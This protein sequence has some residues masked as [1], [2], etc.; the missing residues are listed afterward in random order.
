MN[1]YTFAVN[2]V[3]DKGVHEKQAGETVQI[4][5]PNE[6]IARSMARTKL[7]DRSPGQQRFHPAE[8]MAPPVAVPDP[9]PVPAAV[10]E[11]TKAPPKTTLQQEAA[12]A[13]KGKPS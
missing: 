10:S 3:N 12:E 1:R 8:L 2:R 7:R 11:G 6:E 5:A 9:A 13:L 4:V